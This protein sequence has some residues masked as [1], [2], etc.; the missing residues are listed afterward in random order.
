MTRIQHSRRH[1]RGAVG[2]NLV[3][4][5]LAMLVFLMIALMFGAAIPA[6]TRG[7][8]YSGNFQQAI[9]VVQHK[10][11]QLR[12]ADYSRL[13]PT[14]MDAR[15]IID[16]TG[17]CSTSGSTTTCYYTTQDGIVSAFGAG[18]VGTIVVS[19]FTPSLIVASGEYTLLSVTVTL[20]WKDSNGASHSYSA[21]TLVSQG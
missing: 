10:L 2:M 8:R 13:N 1:R 18:A 15:N 19:P 4:V 5:L 11:D 9:S 20:T 21:S 7:T 6:A 16:S 3:E 17:T 14:E 12:E